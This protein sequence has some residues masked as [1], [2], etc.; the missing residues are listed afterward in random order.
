[1][2]LSHITEGE[3]RARSSMDPMISSAGYGVAP[4]PWGTVQAAAWAAV[5]QGK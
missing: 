3:G 2:A 5:E 1:L 4:T